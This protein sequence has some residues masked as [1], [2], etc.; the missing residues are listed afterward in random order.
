MPQDHTRKQP[1][2]TDLFE[3]VGHGAGHRGPESE[4]RG[5]PRRNLVGCYGLR[6]GVL[7]CKLC[8]C[9]EQRLYIIMCALNSISL[10]PEPSLGLS[11]ELFC[12]PEVNS[13]G[14]ILELILHLS[15]KPSLQLSPELYLGHPEASLE[16]LAPKC[17]S[18][19]NPPLYPVLKCILAR[20][21]SR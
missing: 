10:S 4:G 8:H 6:A 17:I 7:V 1:C 16:R 3:S 14:L 19:P 21:G 11:P 9:P 12:C 20:N 13:L 5:S 15:P 2:S 18:A